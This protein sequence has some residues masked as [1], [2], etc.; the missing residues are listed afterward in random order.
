[1]SGAYI[2]Y[3]NNGS[4]YSVSSMSFLERNSNAVLIKITGT[5]MPGGLH[6][7]LMANNNASSYIEI[8]SEIY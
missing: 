1:M 6:G 4:Y 7:T 3:G 5:N 2:I 8:D